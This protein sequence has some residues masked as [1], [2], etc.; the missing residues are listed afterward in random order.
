[1]LCF[2]FIHMSA[3]GNLTLVLAI[4]VFIFAVVGTQLFGK[5][6]KKH[7]SKI[8]DD[9]K[10]RWHMMDFFHSFLIIFRILCGEWLETMWDC[11]VVAG[12]PLC[13]IVFLLAMVIGNLVVLN[14]FIAL[15]LNSFSAD[16]LQA[17]EDDAEMNNLQIAFARIHK[18][19]R[20]LK[21]TT[22]DYCCGK[23]RQPKKATK[24]KMKLAAE[25]TCVEIGKE[26][27]NCKENHSDNV[28]E[29]NGE[30][31]SV[32]ILEDFITNPN[33]FVCVPIAEAESDSENYEED[34][35]NSSTFTK[36]EYSKQVRS[37]F[38]RRCLRLRLFNE[39]G[40]D[41]A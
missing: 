39:A 24:K 15:L 20:L 41:I 2:M 40:K 16:N 13:L 10:P 6:Y 36:M 14:L 26:G 31:C 28:T 35:N 38:R 11:M 5:S 4:I 12:Q 18:G 33:M 29:K 21:H 17:P 34:D 30:K 25:N 19:L 7:C 37:L 22:W 3:V 1:M 8:S 32:S 27:K 9:C 23:L